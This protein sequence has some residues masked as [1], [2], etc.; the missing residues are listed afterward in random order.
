MRILSH[1]VW[2]ILPAY[3]TSSRAPDASVPKQKMD[4]TLAWDEIS[5]SI[6]NNISPKI[7][8]AGEQLT[9]TNEKIHDVQSPC[10][11]ILDD[12]SIHPRAYLG[13]G[14]SPIPCG[15]VLNS[16]NI[17]LPGRLE[18]EGQNG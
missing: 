6:A 7:G 4:R 18:D 10:R 5:H 8:Q 2:L 14:G 17:S 13:D 1:G 11:Q 3:R 12:S 16:S 15:Q 9:L